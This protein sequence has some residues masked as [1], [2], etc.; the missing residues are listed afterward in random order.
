M[1]WLNSDGLAMREEHWLGR[2]NYLLAY[3]LKTSLSEITNAS[4][5]IVIFNNSEHVKTFNL[6][7]PEFNWEVLLDTSQATGSPLVKHSDKIEHLEISSRSIVIVGNN[8][9]EK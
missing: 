3:K 4:S 9:S 6:P 7:N 8:A 2:N 5:I 1:H